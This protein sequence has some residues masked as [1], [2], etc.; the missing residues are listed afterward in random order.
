MSCCQR[1]VLRAT[2][3]GNR[4]NELVA[5]YHYLGYK[6]LGG[7]QMRYTI[8]ERIADRSPCLASLPRHGS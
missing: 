7:A 5:S 1:P 3:E 2:R 4:W 6:T 8:H